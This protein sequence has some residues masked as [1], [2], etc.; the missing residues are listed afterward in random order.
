MNNENYKFINLGWVR[1]NIFC[2][3]IG[4][5]LETV[6][7]YRAKGVWI[8]GHVVKYAPD[9]R[10]YGNFQHFDLWVEGDQVA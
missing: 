10:L 4:I 2:E 6:K 3:I 5:P 1:I 8:D 9:G 7:S